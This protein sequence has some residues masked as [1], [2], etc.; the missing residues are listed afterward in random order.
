MAKALWQI[1]DYLKEKE[2]QTEYDKDAHTLFSTLSLPEGEIQSRYY[3]D[4][5]MELLSSQCIFLESFPQ[6]RYAALCELANRFNAELGF[7]AFV[8]LEEEDLMFEISYLVEENTVL[9]PEVVDKL[10]MIPSE[11]L[12][13]H[14]PAFLEVAKGKSAREVFESFWQ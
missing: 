14:L 6:D 13:E 2:V 11:A 9:S 12:T 7:G 3:Y 5:D 8:I 4:R 10:A 1:T